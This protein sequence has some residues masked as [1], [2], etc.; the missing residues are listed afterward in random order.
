MCD[1]KRRGA[2]HSDMISMHFFATFLFGSLGFEVS[3]RSR[4]FKAQSPKT[5]HDFVATEMALKRL[6]YVIN[7]FLLPVSKFIEHYKMQFS[8]LASH[9]VAETRRAQGGLEKAGLDMHR[10]NLC[11]FIYQTSNRRKSFSNEH[12]QEDKTVIALLKTQIYSNRV[13]LFSGI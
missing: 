9:S 12:G 1:S 6:Q 4:H 10:W 5:N 7:A 8:S 13:I 2:K 3:R 11:R